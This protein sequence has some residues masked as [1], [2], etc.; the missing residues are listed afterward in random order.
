[1]GKLVW[2]GWQKSAENAPQPTS[3]IYG[4]NIRRPDSSI[5]DDRHLSEQEETEDF[6]VELLKKS[7][8]PLTRKNYLGLAYPEGVPSDLDETSLPESIR[9]L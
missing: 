1:M 3:A 4:A 2:K 6:V 8:L 9:D 5:P 7:G